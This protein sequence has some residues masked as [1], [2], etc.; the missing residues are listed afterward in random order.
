MSPPVY[1][2]RQFFTCLCTATY[3]IHRSP[4]LL[5]PLGFPTPPSSFYQPPPPS[6]TAHSYHTTKSPP[7]SEHRKLCDDDG[8]TLVE[9]PLARAFMPRMEG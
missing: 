7:W 5:S 9:K 4:R 2:I 1:P 6:L 3:P 8:E